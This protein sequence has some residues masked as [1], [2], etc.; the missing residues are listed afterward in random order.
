MS[1]EYDQRTPQ[2]HTARKGRVTGSNVGAILG[3]DPWR[4][5]DDVLRTMVREYHGAER[6][7]TGNVATE[8][9]TANEDGARWAYELETG[10]TVAPSGFV[11]FEDW[12]G[13]SPDGYVGDDGLIEI[14]SP[15]SRKIK[16]I[17][18]QPHYHAQI[19]VQLFVTGRE[20]CH[21]WTWTPSGCALETVQYSQEWIDENLPRL[22][23]FHALYLSELDNPE[24]L[25][26]KRAEVNTQ[27]TK[28][29]VDELDQ[30]RDAIAQAEE[31]RKEVEAALIKACGERNAIVWGRKLTRVE[32]AGSI[33]YAKA[34]KELAPSADLEKWRGK[35]STYWKIG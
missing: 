34:V 1:T 35:P 5:A 4:S 18:D 17:A 23:Q 16:P 7:F 2:W 8:W 31:R 14:K 11:P 24:H 30:L 9:G 15:Y 22:R 26:P 32:R 25:E 27:E 28:L 33:S 20:W 12:L 21:F 13:A 29:L 3:L 19:Q 6:E 10:N